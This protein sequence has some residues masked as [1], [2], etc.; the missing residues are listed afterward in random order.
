[1]G[2]TDGRRGRSLLEQPQPESIRRLVMLRQP[3]PPCFCR[4]KGEDWNSGGG[5]HHAILGPRGLKAGI[6]P[7]HSRASGNPGA[8]VKD[9]PLSPLG[10]RFRGDERTV[11]T[12]GDGSCA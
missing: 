10:P 7:A 8:K 5:F 11:V 3:L 9:R 2:V 12:P 4:C 6:I 1:F